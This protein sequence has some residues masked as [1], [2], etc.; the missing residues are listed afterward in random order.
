MGPFREM[1]W[2]SG[3][4]WS[5]ISCKLPSTVRLNVRD[6]VKSAV[7]RLLVAAI[8][9]GSV[10]TVSAPRIARAE[11]AD[12]GPV[13]ATIMTPE[14]ARTIAKM[15][16]VWGWPLVNLH[17]RR[18]A[19]RPITSTVSVEGLRMA[20]M[21]HLAMNSDYV[22]PE[23]RHV[24]HPNQDVVYGAG[25]ISIDKGPVVIQVPDFGD[26]FWVYQLANQRTDA[27]GNLGKMYAT[28]P[29]FYMIVGKDWKGKLPKGINAA[30]KVDTA[31]GA[32][33]P[34]I[35]M[36]D[37]TE[38]RAEIQSV[39]NQVVM[40]PLADFNGKMKVV[41]WNKTPSMPT[42]GTKTGKGERKWVVPSKFFDQLGIV[43]D[44]V[45]PLPGEEALYLQFRALLANAAKDVVV[46][47][48]ITRAA[49]EAEKEIVDPLFFLSNNG[50]A[51]PHN[52]T[53]IF[54]GAAF[55]TDYL[56]RLAIAKSN[57]FVNQNKE[58]NYFYQYHD[59]AGKRLIG[60]NRYSLTFTKEQLP[61]VRGFWSLTMYNSEHFFYLNELNRYSIGTKNKSMKYSPDG[62]LT[63]YVQHDKPSDDL[64]SNWLP[65][66]PD[67]FAMTIRTYWPEATVANGEWVPPKVHRVE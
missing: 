22:D 28:K 67:E 8:V 49:E 37:T 18:E 24:A 41:D 48:A 56:T 62:S 13:L 12:N 23:Q 15:A 58:S 51:L 16:Y 52:W 36:A 40:Y 60:T 19:F 46:K 20:P 30:F 9:A 21:N 4:W 64:V 31:V 5:R 26:R 39:V 34:R 59:G 10:S 43:L 29:G 1:N 61:K 66:P 32:V 27:F 3:D 35:F 33:L 2:T 63:L 11:Q 50:V 44:E 42:Q 14:Y 17:N 25:V 38:D 55:G 47:A 45:P 6:I 53:R 7:K 57:I 65:A 54:N